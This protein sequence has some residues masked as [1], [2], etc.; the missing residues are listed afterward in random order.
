M[1]CRRL[2]AWLSQNC[3]DF[4][5][6]NVSQ[7]PTAVDE[8][9]AG[10]FNILPVAVIADRSVTG[11]HDQWSECIAQLKTH[12]GFEDDGYDDYEYELED[13]PR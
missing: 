11:F 1:T 5:D 13:A 6:R 8:L 7:D 2:K 3:V 10:G 4:E 9:K 12:L